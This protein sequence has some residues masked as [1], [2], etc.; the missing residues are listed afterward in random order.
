MGVKKCKNKNPITF[1]IGGEEQLFIVTDTLLISN[2]GKFFGDTDF[3]SY[4]VL[5]LHCLSLTVH[6]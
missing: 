5:K 3:T 4:Q 2:W 1:L 6:L